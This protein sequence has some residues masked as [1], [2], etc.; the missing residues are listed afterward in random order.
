MGG[1]IG[2][3]PPAI[4]PV[5]GV[6]FARVIGYEK[7]GVPVVVKIA[8]VHSHTGFGVPI[9]I[10]LHPGSQAA[11]DKVPPSVFVEKIW[12]AVVGHVNIRIA[13]QVAVCKG[14]A[15]PPSH[16]MDSHPLGHIDKA[17]PI[18]AIEHISNGRVGAWLAVKANRPPLALDIALQAEMH[19]IDHKEV[20]ISIVVEI[21]KS[22][23][24][25]PAPVAHAG[26]LGD[27]RK[28]AAAVIAQ[29]HIG[30]EVGRVEILIPIV[31]E[32]ARRTSHAVAPVAG[33]GLDTEI[34]ESPIAGVA[35]E[36][37]DGRGRGEGPRK[38]GTI[39]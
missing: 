23:A 5:E 2:K 1:K 3:A 14:H 34:G 19:I 20:Q 25:A 17:S 36:A 37:V 27:V 9:F 28:A 24:G 15:Q 30:A 39:D 4:V 10:V 21:Q 16:R 29:Q 35:I 12:R 22:G 38:M 6:G 33:P 7:I 31:V 13:V 26:H 32:I 18:V 8:E 11:L